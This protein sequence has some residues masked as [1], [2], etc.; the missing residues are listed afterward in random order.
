MFSYCYKL[1][2]LDLSNFNTSRVTDDFYFMSGCS[3]LTQITTSAAVVNKIATYL[4]T[5]SSSAPGYL[6]VDDWTSITVGNTL[7][8]K[9]W[10]YDPNSFQ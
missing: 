2:T 9:Y 8:S 4:P 10:Q 5:R 1:T 3:N 6:I 7:N